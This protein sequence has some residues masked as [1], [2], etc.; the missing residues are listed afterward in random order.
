M[1]LDKIIEKLG[2]GTFSSVHKVVDETG[3]NEYALKI[4]HL[5]KPKKKYERDSLKLYDFSIFLCFKE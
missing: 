3:K 2:K 5:S 1:Y 4:V